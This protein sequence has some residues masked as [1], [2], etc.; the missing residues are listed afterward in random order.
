MELKKVMR[1]GHLDQGLRAL[2]VDIRNKLGDH[3]T[4]VEIGS[5]MGESAEI[6]AQELPNS[7]IIC[8]DPWEGGFDKKDP[9]SYDNYSEVERQFNLR[10]HKYRNIEKRKGYST[11]FKI[12]C[13]VIYID[14]RHSYE[15]VKEDILHWSPCVKSI[16]SGHDYYDVNSQT[17]INHPHIQGVKIAVDEMFTNPDNTY[18]DSSWIKYL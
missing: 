18:Q 16:F 13:D 10:F 9:C 11:S 6:F 3:I 2:A 1:N 15:G 14:G 4:L 7:K 12:K 17:Y 5:Y 8:I